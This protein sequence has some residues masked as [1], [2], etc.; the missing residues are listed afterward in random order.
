M[1]MMKRLFCGLVFGALLAGNVLAA[2]GE[3]MVCGFDSDSDLAV[4]NI[5]HN[6]SVCTISTELAN[7]SK[8]SL[9][10]D[11]PSVTGEVYPGF[12]VS[13]NVKCAAPGWDTVKLNV[14]KNLP[15]NWKD[16]KYIKIDVYNASAFPGSLN[17][18]IMGKELETDIKK[19]FNKEADLPKKKWKTLVYRMSDIAE[20]MS[21]D[22][23]R[24][25]EFF[26][27]ATPAP[28]TIYFDNLRMSK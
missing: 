23:I 14:C 25:I 19:S 1:K 12:M 6:D 9:K 3:I 27:L 18:K 15:T 22:E 20:K 4:L 13:N 16:Y 26:M 8:G 28:Y 11:I 10:V 5:N 2:D 21:I 17:I 7:D 24:Q